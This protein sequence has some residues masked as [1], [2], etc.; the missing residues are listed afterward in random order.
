MRLSV[1]SSGLQVC[2]QVFMTLTLVHTHWLSYVWLLQM[3]QPMP[4][5]LSLC[6]HSP[7]HDCFSQ[8][9]LIGVNSIINY[10][11][12]LIFYVTLPTGSTGLNIFASLVIGN[13]IRA[14]TDGILVTPRD[15]V[16][17]SAQLSAHL[18]LGLSSW[19]TPSQ[20]TSSFSIHLARLLQS[21]SCGLLPFHSKNFGVTPSCAR[22]VD[23]LDSWR[24]AWN[25][26]YGRHCTTS[27]AKNSADNQPVCQW[28]PVS[29]MTIPALYPKGNCY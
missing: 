2:P 25:R 16:R 9:D 14:W 5:G 1:C 21:M 11:F 3:L 6:A 17:C 15:L 22:R 24:P 20:S 18:R 26:D 29:T 13:N 27:G 28:P 8:P 23:K 19:R 7:C 4:N 12:Y 10:R